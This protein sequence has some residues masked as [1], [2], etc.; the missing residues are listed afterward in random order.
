[1]E[2]E[3][4]YYCCYCG[5]KIEVDDLEYNKAGDPCHSDCKYLEQDCNGD[6]NSY[7]GVSEND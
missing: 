7:Y 6:Y 5:K 4:K 1:M 2:F 3:E